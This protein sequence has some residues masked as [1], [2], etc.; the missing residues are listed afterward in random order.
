[1][2]PIS[3]VYLNNHPLILSCPEEEPEEK[4]SFKIQEC[5]LPA[6]LQAHFLGI[7]LADD[8]VE[9]PRTFFFER[10]DRFRILELSDCDSI[11]ETDSLSYTPPSRN[12]ISESNTPGIEEIKE[13][14][15]SLNQDLKKTAREIQLKA[16]NLLYVK[17]STLKNPNIPFHTVIEEDLILIRKLHEVESKKKLLLTTLKQNKNYPWECLQYKEP[18]SEYAI[19][20]LSQVLEECKKIILDLSLLEGRLSPIQ[21]T[22][23]DR[24]EDYK[25]IFPHDIY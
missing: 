2:I 16:N 7:A 19:N 15:N 14:Q 11:S 21:K 8:S 23:F 25:V 22:L 5:S 9:Q 4:L 17:V 18:I 10:R 20:Q 13:I 3:Q 12:Y 6:L 24:Y 1:M